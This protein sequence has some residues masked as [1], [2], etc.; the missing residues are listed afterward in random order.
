L[1]RTGVA[2]FVAERYLEPVNTPRPSA[3]PRIRDMSPPS[4][5]SGSNEPRT[6]TSSERSNNP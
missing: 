5:T 6:R 4:R 3:T 1:A 2:P